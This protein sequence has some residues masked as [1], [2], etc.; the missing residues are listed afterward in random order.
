MTDT[1][2]LDGRVVLLTGAAGGIG[3][4]AAGLLAGAGARLALFDR[5]AAGL[6]DLLGGL[7]APARHRAWTLDLLDDA[8]R[9]A[10]L[11]EVLAHFGRIDVLVN[12]AGLLVGG[13]FETASAAGLR[14]L[15]GVNLFAP[16]A[17]TAEVLPAM[18]SQGSGH[19]VNVISSAGL[20]A[21]PGFAGYNATKAGLFIFSRTLRRELRGSGIRV[22]AFCPGSTASPM[23]QGMLDAGGSPGGEPAHG[24]SLPAHGLLDAVLRPRDLVVVSSRP[25]GQRIA[26]FLD[27]VFPRL[28]DRTWAARCDEAYY[29][30][31]ARG[32]RRD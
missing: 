11:A 1:P 20:L 7:P 13:R 12:N 2:A 31:V 18:R 24:V 30:L 26:M 8:A 27:R 10:A 6:E 15:V 29:A 32:G 22:T 25:V 3:A 9:A 4:A 5:D 19:I 14:A 16:L 21:V 17:L 28:L 23:T